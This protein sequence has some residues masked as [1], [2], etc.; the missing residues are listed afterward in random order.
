MTAFLLVFFGAL[1]VSVFHLVRSHLDTRLVVSIRAY[2]HRLAL[3]EET[4]DT[5]T[6]D[7]VER[8]IYAQLVATTWLPARRLQSFHGLLDKA[9]GIRENGRL[10]AGQPAS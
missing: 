3:A 6:V 9:R 4:G 7:Q 2:R 1:V 10:N 8:E 5:S